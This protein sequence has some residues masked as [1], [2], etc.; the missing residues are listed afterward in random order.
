[1]K[2][3][4]IVAA[5]LMPG[6]AAAV[7]KCTG[8]DG[9]VSYQAEPCEAGKAEKLRLQP[10]PAAAPDEVVRANAVS[11]GRIMVGMTTEQVRRAWGSPTKINGS[12][13]SYGRHE[14][15]VYDRGDFRFQYVYIQNGVVTGMQSPE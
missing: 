15:W 10:V 7:N 1:M 8:A 13:G 6:W 12:T 4:F 2:K 5:L 9:S 11:M 3:L 14:Q